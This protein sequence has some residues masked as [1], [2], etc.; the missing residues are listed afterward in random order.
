MIIILIIEKDERIAVDFEYEYRDKEGQWYRAYGLEHW[1][2]NKEGIMTN[3]ETS[4][5]D[6]KISQN[7]RKFK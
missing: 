4:I 7:D 1:I 6:V 3:R 5:N 2:F